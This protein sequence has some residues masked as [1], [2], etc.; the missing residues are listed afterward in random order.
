MLPLFHAAN[1]MM[2]KNRCTGNFEAK[3]KKV[4]VEKFF[5]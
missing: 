1:A 4:P 3:N 5:R 2:K